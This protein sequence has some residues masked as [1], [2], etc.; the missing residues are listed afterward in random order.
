[1]TPTINYYGDVFALQSIIHIMRF[2][3]AQ[4]CPGSPLRRKEEV[5]RQLYVTSYLET[6]LQFSSAVSGV[7]SL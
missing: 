5:R 6:A 7:N 2:R 1:M 4:A 3:L